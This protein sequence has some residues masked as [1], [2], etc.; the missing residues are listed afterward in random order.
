MSEQTP[1][2]AD[3]PDIYLDI[4]KE[5][6]G[7]AASL[8]WLPG[9]LTGPVLLTRVPSSAGDG[10]QLQ[11][12]SA[13]S[14]SAP[15]LPDHPKLVELFG[16]DCNLLAVPSDELPGLR[17]LLQLVQP[18]LRSLSDSVQRSISMQDSDAEAHPDE[19]LTQLLQQTVQLAARYV[20]AKHPEHYQQLL[21]SGQL[22]QLVEMAAYSA[23][24]LLETLTLIAPDGTVTSRQ[25]AA[26]A[27]VSE[28]PAEADAAGLGLT[29]KVMLVNTAQSP[30]SQPGRA[31]V[32][33]RQQQRV[34][35]AA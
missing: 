25:L 21:Q 5:L 28:V 3:T 27:A 16:S 13:S 30:G 18:A 6:T 29:V 10:P 1:V 20:Y 7:A 24:G 14:T 2:S 35:R 15:F 9:L 31:A 11:F 23:P 32:W 12:V 4:L 33:R 26:G 34:W 8:A 17:P 19:E 22:Q